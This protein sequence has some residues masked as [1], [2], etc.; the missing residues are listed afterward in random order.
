M[1]KI[2]RLIYP[3]GQQLCFAHLIQLSINDV[4][5]KKGVKQYEI[6]PGEENPTSEDNCTTGDKYGNDR[7]D[8]MFIAFEQAEI[9]QTDDK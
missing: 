4:L 5:Y 9:A 1:T 7:D 2:G 6:S 3:V 8:L